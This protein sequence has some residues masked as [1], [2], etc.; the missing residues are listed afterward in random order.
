MYNKHFI[1][2]LQIY[3]HPLISQ[4][5]KKNNHH[6]A[7]D[8]STSYAGDKTTYKSRG[9]LA[10]RLNFMSSALTTCNSTDHRLQSI[11]LQRHHQKCAEAK[12]TWQDAKPVTAAPS[13]TQQCTIPWHPNMQAMFPSIIHCM[14]YYRPYSP[15]RPHQ[16]V[17]PYL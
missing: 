16:P 8:T 15:R 9:D 1:I 13:N 5:G 14:S 6:L 2:P 10:N 7:S 4:N 3:F 17:L 12:D 11:I